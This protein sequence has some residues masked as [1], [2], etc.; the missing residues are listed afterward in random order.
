MEQVVK[1]DSLL[2]LH[3]RV[4]LKD[5]TEVLSTFDSSPAT[6][7]L[8]CGELAPPLERCLIDLPVG[9]RSAFVLEPRDAFGEYDADRVQRVGRLHLPQE[10]E[11]EVLSVVEVEQP[12]GDTY[13]GVVAELDGDSALIDFNHPLAGKA[14]R[15]EVEVIGIL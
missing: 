3:Y 8:G 2:T 7:K 6:L 10:P 12:D 15:F 4:M 1:A 11:L 13:A 9:K 5:G 14:I